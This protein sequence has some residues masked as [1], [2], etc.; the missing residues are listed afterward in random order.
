MTVWNTKLLGTVN[1]S[2]VKVVNPDWSNIGSP[3]S[4][5]MLANLPVDTDTDSYFWYT[6][7]DWSWLIKKIAES[8][9]SMRY[10][11]GTSDYEDN[12]DDRDTLTYNLWE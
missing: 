11:K 7:A 10:A 2:P 1:K 6:K 9:N 3:T 4:S 5:Y 8:D 12:W